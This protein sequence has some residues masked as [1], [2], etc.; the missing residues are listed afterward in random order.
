MFI[1]GV[2]RL[3]ATYSRHDL[4]LVALVSFVIG[5]PDLNWIHIICCSKVIR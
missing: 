3:S 4:D 2:I 5:E 1:M